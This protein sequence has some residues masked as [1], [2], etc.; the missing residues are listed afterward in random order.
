MGDEYRKVFQKMKFH[1]RTVKKELHERDH[2]IST[3][4]GYLR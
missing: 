2:L 4:C 1:L 3:A